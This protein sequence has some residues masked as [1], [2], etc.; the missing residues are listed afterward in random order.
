MK[1]LDLGRAI[2]VLANLGVIAGILLLVVEL[3]QNNAL[4]E[5]QS[6]FGMME[7]GVELTTLQAT[8]IG[9]SELLVKARSGESLTREEDLRLNSWGYRHLQAW[10]WE[11]GEFQ[12]GALELSDLR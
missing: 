2:S 7:L 8:D 6:R 1:K 11:Y 5:A 9:L 10:Q 4:L 12:V 3:Q